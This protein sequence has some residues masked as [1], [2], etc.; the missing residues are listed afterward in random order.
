[1]S[2]LTVVKLNAAQAA[3][4]QSRVKRTRNRS[5]RVRDFVTDALASEHGMSVGVFEDQKALSAFSANVKRIAKTL[6]I[7]AE[8]LQ[9]N[10]MYLFVRRA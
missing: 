5:S 9:T 4:L 10:D 1:M 6:N 2:Q 7:R 3:E 8:V